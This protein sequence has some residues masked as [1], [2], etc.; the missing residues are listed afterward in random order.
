[1]IRPASYRVDTPTDC[2]E[3]VRWVG[4]KSVGKGRMRLWGCEGHVEGLE[5]V[6]PRQVVVVPAP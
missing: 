1:M 6:R 5:D 4:R 3:P 2:T